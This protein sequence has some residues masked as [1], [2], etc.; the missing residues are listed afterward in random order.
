M[1]RAVG[2]VRSFIAVT[3]DAAGD[4]VGI[5]KLRQL[6]HLILAGKV[7][8]A[9]GENGDDRRKDEGDRNG[10]KG[11][12]CLGVRPERAKEGRDR[13]DRSDEHRAEAD[14]I[15]A[16]EVRPFELDVGWTQFEQGF[17]DHQIGDHRPNPG[18]SHI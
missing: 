13:D 10:Q 2:H 9:F 15:N 7:V 12:E 11:R 6:A 16:V 18:N 1:E 4:D 14:G 17:V 8:F 3:T 5:A